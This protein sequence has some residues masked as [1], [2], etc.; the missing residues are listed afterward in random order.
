M[1]REGRIRVNERIRA[2]EI[3]VI[4]EDGHQLGVMHPQDALRMARERELD[5]VEVAPNGQPPVCRIMDFGKYLYQMSKRAHEARRHQKQ[6]LVKEIKLRPQ[7]DEH[8]YQF[9]KNHIIRFLSD[10][11][12][13]RISVEF[14]GREITHK[15]IGRKMIDRLIAELKEMAELEKSPA[16]EGRYLT[17]ILAP[18]KAAKSAGEHKSQKSAAR[19]SS[20]RDDVSSQT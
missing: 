15:E 12:K 5:L 18:K 10:G 1:G 16:M 9:K 2:R 11:N 3:R 7:T 19:P 13:A 20:V 17:A 8:D 6:V 14:K 4:D